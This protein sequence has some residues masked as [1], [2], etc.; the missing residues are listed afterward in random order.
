MN[1][2]G[3]TIYRDT[4]RMLLTGLVLGVLL[5]RDLASRLVVGFIVC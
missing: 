3:V 5:F 1:G 2:I 4:G